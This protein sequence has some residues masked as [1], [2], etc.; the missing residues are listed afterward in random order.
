M[1]LLSFP[2]ASRGNP[3]SFFTMNP[4]YPP[5][6]GPSLSLQREEGARYELIFPLEFVPDYF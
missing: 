5:L 4:S 3:A 6:A 1:K 2:H